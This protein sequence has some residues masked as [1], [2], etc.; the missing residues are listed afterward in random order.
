ME[1]K[2]L[3]DLKEGDTVVIRS[4]GWASAPYRFKT[5]TKITKTQIVCGDYRY[6][7]DSGF[8]VGS[9]GWNRER[10]SVPTETD[11]I[12]YRV[13]VAQCKL[14]KIVVKEENLT[15]V[16]ELLKKIAEQKANNENS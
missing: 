14:E 12:G 16:E 8:L 11:Y 4:Y 7:R 10:I 3:E 2:K 9:E 1:E 15:F 6:R 5:I 13:Y